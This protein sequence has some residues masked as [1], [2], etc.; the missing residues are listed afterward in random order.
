MCPHPPAALT[1]HSA[2]PARFAVVAF[3]VLLAAQGRGYYTG[4]LYVPLL[5]G[6]AVLFEQW[7]AALA[8]RQR[9]WVSVTAWTLVALFGVMV[10]AMMLPL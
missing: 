7:L 2:A 6:G 3:L 1:R 10:A 4:P 8:P 9:R 5:A